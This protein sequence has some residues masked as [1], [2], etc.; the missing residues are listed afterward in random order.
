MNLHPNDRLAPKRRNGSNFDS[1]N[2][3]PA[4]KVPRKRKRVRNRLQMKPDGSIVCEVVEEE[5]DDDDVPNPITSK[6]NTSLVDDE[7]LVK[8]ELGDE[9]NEIDPLLPVEDFNKEPLSPTFLQASNPTSA[10]VKVEVK[11]EDEIKTEDPTFL[12]LTNPFTASKFK[13]E[14]NRNDEAEDM[15]DESNIPVIDISEPIVVKTLTTQRTPLSSKLPQPRP[16]LSKNNSSNKRTNR[17][18][19]PPATRGD[20]IDS[21]YSAVS[22][23]S[24]VH[25]TNNSV[26]EEQQPP[27]KLAEEVEARVDWVK[28]FSDP[29][30]ADNCPC[31]IEN[32]LEVPF[33]NK[34]WTTEKRREIVIKG[35]PKKF[36]VRFSG[37]VISH[38][39]LDWLT[40]CS[41]RDELYCWPCL[42]FQPKSPWYSK[43]SVLS[44]DSLIHQR[45]FDHKKSVSTLNRLE[46]HFQKL[47]MKMTSKKPTPAKYSE[48]NVLP[49]P[50]PNLN[51]TKDTGQPSKKKTYSCIV[52][53]LIDKNF[54]DL[55]KEE[56]ESILLIGR[57]R[58]QLG[59]LALLNRCQ[60][61]A[62]EYDRVE[63]LT[64]S[65]E[66]KKLYCWPC[67]LG[68]QNSKFGVWTKL[69][70]SEF[71]FLDDAVQR[72]EASLPHM[73]AY[74]QLKVWE[75]EVK[76][77]SVGSTTLN[78]QKA[79]KRFDFL[80][81]VVDVTCFMKQKIT[82]SATSIDDYVDVLKLVSSR[83]E[84]LKNFFND[85]SLKSDEAIKTVITP[86]VKRISASLQLKML[87]R[88]KEELKKTHFV[89]LILSD[90][91]VHDKMRN[92]YVAAIVRYTTETGSPCERFVKF[93]KAATDRPIRNFLEDVKSLVNQLDC[94]QKLVGFTYDGGVVQSPMIKFFNNEMKQVF[95]SSNFFH[96][97]SHNLR[98][99]ITQSLSHV[100]CCKD[101]VS[102]LTE[103]SSFF[104]NTPN[105]KASFLS[106]IT[107]KQ[108]RE[109]D[110]SSGLV[111][112]I[113]NNYFSLID[114]FDSIKSNGM[115]F[116]WN[117]KV[118][119]QADKFVRFL[120]RLSNRF[121]IV[122]LSRIFADVDH[123]CQVLEGKFDTT[124]VMVGV[125][126]AIEKIKSNNFDDI[127][128]TA[129]SIS[130]NEPRIVFPGN[131][132][133]FKDIFQQVINVVSL[134]LTDRTSDMEKWDFFNFMPG[135]ESC[136]K[137]LEAARNRISSS[138]LAISVF[139]SL[140]CQ[141][142]HPQLVLFCNNERF[143]GNKDID[144]LVRCLHDFDMVG[145]VDELYKFLM[146]IRSVP[147]IANDSKIPKINKIN[148][149]IKGKKELNDSDTLLWLER[150]LLS[151]LQSEES[152]H[153]D[154]INDIIRDTKRTV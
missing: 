11:T 48:E 51:L 139:P 101:F 126:N 70:F 77:K 45:T 135:N 6:C 63:W 23:S 53:K 60:S 128:R 58:P 28:R 24:P 19:V 79:R 35:K 67:L 140:D 150:D 78:D 142:L 13:N 124:S 10:P 110:F 25:V 97:K 96:Y 34:Q 98:K 93:I 36:P 123:L 5:I 69:G 152:F 44:D 80:K 112:T 136:G 2:W 91:S 83:D 42:L 147:M 18:N 26:G 149:Y 119:A 129:C 92:T 108:T 99:L 22:P 12:K 14:L 41:A 90:T 50:T 107:R 121:L 47:K 130:S 76:K 29:V 86:Y 104:D 1:S 153:S 120:L 75:S 3:E 66:H 52:S 81:Y 113:V 37:A 72:H 15:P 17:E 57:P 43:K 114:F 62:Q 64:A 146:F 144:G 111:L 59:E 131:R 87:S 125:S 49:K 137:Y 71:R 46:M 56:R 89:S 33:L 31:I 85:K 39:R 95:T 9:G 16:F 102:S 40:G 8:L 122:L 127:F 154:V 138:A 143:F 109:W 4:E 134:L 148:A 54:S 115:A 133:I 27:V 55:D 21:S 30:V 105:A 88:I 82:N 132:D 32:L 65:L 74:L 61:S 7:R 106:L 38:D 145:V 103:I 141:R 68:P 20:V 73:D 151:T 84:K 117:N 94:A 118:K 100:K 116:E